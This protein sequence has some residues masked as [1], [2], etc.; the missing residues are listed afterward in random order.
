MALNVAGEMPGR[1]YSPWLERERGS[2]CRGGGAHVYVM[3]TAT[4]FALGP[5]GTRASHARVVAR[6]GAERAGDAR[7]V[8][9]HAGS[10][11]A[12]HC[13]RSRVVGAGTA[14]LFPNGIAQGSRMFNLTGL[15]QALF[16]LGATGRA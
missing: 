3:L 14:G 10:R 2:P 13:G 5:S 8:L 1:G 7:D 11:R 4:R 15:R 6:R 12:G 16:E 9:V